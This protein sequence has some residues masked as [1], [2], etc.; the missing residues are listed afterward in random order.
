[1]DQT[2]IYHNKNIESKL[3]CMNMVTSYVLECMHG[4]RKARLFFS[5]LKEST[6][7]RKIRR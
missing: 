5:K 4:H 2:Y 3:K 6:T 7:K 1:M